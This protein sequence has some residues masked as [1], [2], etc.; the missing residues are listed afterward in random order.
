[1]RNI[2]AK[3]L[4]QWLEEG[5]ATLVDVREPAEYRASRIPGALLMPLAQVDAA[6]LPG[7]RIVVHCQ[8]GGRG[9]AACEKLLKQNPALEIYNLTGGIEG[10]D[11]AGLDVERGESNA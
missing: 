10:W 3:N 11:A 2:D 5:S 1:M 7:G 6:R 9:L 4:K 8:K